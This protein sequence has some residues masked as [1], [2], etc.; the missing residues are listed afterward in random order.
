VTRPLALVDTSPRRPFVVGAPGRPSAAPRSCSRSACPRPAEATLHF[1]YAGREAWIDPL[2]L[3]VDPGVYDLCEDHAS[4]TRPPHGWTLRDRRPGD[5]RPSDDTPPI[6]LEGH[7][8]AVVSTT[9]AA[10]GDPPVSEDGHGTA[11]ALEVDR[12]DTPDGPGTPAI[13]TEG[14]AALHGGVD[15]E[16]RNGHVDAGEASDASDTAIGSSRP[17]APLTARPA[18]PP[19]PTPPDLASVLTAA[20]AL[21]GPGPSEGPAVT[22]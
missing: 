7:R 22:W 12:A 19:A 3:R 14:A 4:R 21:R 5:A 6:D 16:V 11:G 10:A 20:R 13:A 15:A 1:D 8:A 18:A 9:P 17:V 2:V